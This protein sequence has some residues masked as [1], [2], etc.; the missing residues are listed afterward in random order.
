MADDSGNLAHAASNARSGLAIPPGA[1]RVAR[2]ITFRVP[3]T[4][5]LGAVLIV[6]PD[7]TVT[8]ETGLSAGAWQIFNVAPRGRVLI[9]PEHLT[10]GLPEWWGAR[11]NDPGFDCQPAIQSCLD[12]CVITRL[13]AA[14]YAI[15][16]TV[17]I[18]VHGRTLAGASADQNGNRRGTRLLL[19]SG[20]LDGLQVG[21]D[22]QPDNSK[23]WLE[24]VT[25]RDLTLLRSAPLEN[26]KEGFANAPAGVRLQWAVTCYLERVE[27]IEHSHGFYITGTVHCFLRYCQA[28]RYKAGTVPKNDF[29]N[30]FFMDNSAASGFNSGNASLYIQNCATFSTQSVPF[31]ESSGIKAYAGYT[32]TFITGFECA[33]VEYGLDLAGRSSTDADYQSED[34]IIDACVIDSPTKGGIRVRSSGPMTVIQIC[35]CYIAPAGSG[36]AFD[37]Q[38]CGGSIGISSCQVIS[39]PG[40]A[41]TGLRAVR[42]SGVSAINNIYTDIRSPMVLEG[43]SECRISDNINNVRQKTEVAAVLAKDL[44]HSLL[45][46]TVRGSPGIHP[47]GVAFVSGANERN[48]VN[49]T[50]IS[51]HAI[52]GGSS[53]ILLFGGRSIASTGPFGANLASGLLG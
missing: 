14:D 1:Y 37:I 25:V 38:D 46:L 40:N 6:D 39:T 48:E 8:F 49:C 42:S 33:L 35:N 19:T 36:S 44:A 15:S 51:P 22:R 4:F 34:L 41:A 27:T 53:A 29:F 21:Y 31:S 32:D 50:G 28:L 2:D 30:G 11:P 9:S 7:I 5:E 45:N 10:E 18:T 43:C 23:H 20:T 24:H 12:A 47:A 16:R 26:P 3:V 17:K 13:H 52:A